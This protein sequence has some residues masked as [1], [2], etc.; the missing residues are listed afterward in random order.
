MRVAVLM[1]IVVGCDGDL[2]FAGPPRDAA[3]T[4]TELHECDRDDQ[5]TEE[6]ARRCDVASHLCVECGTS[7]DCEDNE[8]CVPASKR[9]MRACG[10]ALICPPDTPVCD[11]RG[12]CVCTAASCTSAEAKLCDPTGRCVECVNDAQCPTEEPHCNLARGRCQ[13]DL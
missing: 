1:L 5:C 4:D 12:I 8:V 3:T 13:S 10:D 7:N 2:R 11:P 6:G 9:C